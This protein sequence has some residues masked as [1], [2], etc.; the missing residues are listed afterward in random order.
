MS[1]GAS[2]SRTTHKLNRCFQENHLAPQGLPEVAYEEFALLLIL[3]T[4]AITRR[5]SLRTQTDD[6]SAVGVHWSC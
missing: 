3:L 5:R 4:V 6:L 2:P 1:F